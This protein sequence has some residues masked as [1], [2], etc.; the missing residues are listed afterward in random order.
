MGRAGLHLVRKGCEREH[1][2]SP[3]NGVEGGGRRRAGWEMTAEQ[4]SALRFKV[5]AG[6]ERF[7]FW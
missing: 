5:L 7:R 6:L 1:R 2:S 3:C 4:D